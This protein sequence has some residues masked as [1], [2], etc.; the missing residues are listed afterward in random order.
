MN[1]YPAW[2]NLL[3]L[4]IVVLGSLLALPNIYGSAPAVQI[5]EIDGRP[6][7]DGMIV[8]VETVLEAAAVSP[9]QT[10]I[11]DG[12][13]VITF[14]SDDD[15]QRSGNI[16]RDRFADVANVAYSSAPELPSFTFCSKS[17]WNRR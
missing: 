17:I 6:F 1:R 16:L 14:S 3:V 7:D 5:S 2:L 15:Q 8:Q 10:F 9:K 11:E 4:G 13:V 12:R